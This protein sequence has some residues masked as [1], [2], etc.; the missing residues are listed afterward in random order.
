[1]AL[2]SP[3]ADL[4]HKAKNLQAEVDTLQQCLHNSH[5]LQGKTLERWNKKA[6]LAITSTSAGPTNHVPVATSTPY[7]SAPSIYSD[8]VTHAHVKA[9]ETAS[10]LQSNSLDLSIT[11]RV[12]AAALH[13]VKLEP[14]VFAGD[15]VIHPEDWLLSVNTYRS[16]LDLSDTQILQELPR[17]LAGEAKKWF[18]VLHT[19]V[20]DWKDIC[21]LFRMV[22]LSSDNQESVMRGTLDHV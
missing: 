1:M 18:S 15:D 8:D 13:Q 3:S 17:F 11:T 19:H 5:D 21:E 4:E 7:V 10:H 12:L 2:L 20:V 9:A 16:S 22:F 14:S 6:K